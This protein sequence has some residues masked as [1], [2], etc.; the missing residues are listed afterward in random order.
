MKG[1]MFQH[2]Q[3]QQVGVEENICNLTSASGEAS[4]ASSGNKTEIGTNYMAP[5]PSQ[6]QQPKKK[7]N[8]LGTLLVSNL[9]LCPCSSL[10]FLTFMSFLCGFIL[11]VL[12]I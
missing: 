10:F 6:T 1:F 7:R 8:L 9:Q 5:P 3:Q 4:A 11:V 12:G 2:Q